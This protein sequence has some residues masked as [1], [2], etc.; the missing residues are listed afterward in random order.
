MIDKALRVLCSFPPLLLLSVPA[1]AEDAPALPAWMAGCWQQGAGEDWT[2]ECW[3]IPRAG[4]LLGSSRTGKAGRIA[5]WE[6]MRIEQ[7]VPNGEGQTVRMTFWAA[8]QGRNW[9]MFAW[10][11]SAEPGVTFASAAHDYPQRIRYWREGE[12]LKAEIS[13]LDGSRAQR[14]TYSPMRP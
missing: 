5:S 10:S 3:T 11:P 6:F 14:W 13:M 2:E 12:Q 7:D 9:T 8:P 4:Q 1:Q